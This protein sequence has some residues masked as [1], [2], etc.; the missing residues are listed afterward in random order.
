MSG[1]IAR[2]PQ[3]GTVHHPLVAHSGSPTQQDSTTTAVST[4]QIPTPTVIIASQPFV[5]RPRHTVVLL[6]RSLSLHSLSI[7]RFSS[8][9]LP[10]VLAVVTLLAYRPLFSPVE[11]WQMMHGDYAQFHAPQCMKQRL[12]W[13]CVIW[14]IDGGAAAE[15][16][17]QNNSDTGRAVEATVVAET[18]RSNIR[19]VSASLLSQCS[20]PSLCCS[21][22]RW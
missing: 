20:S 13:P 6:A 16:G 10:F 3:W 19:V 18:E 2:P 9:C 5:A 7:M 15:F 8:V 21:N 11:D 1:A 12:S 4:R 22:R 17:G 14:M